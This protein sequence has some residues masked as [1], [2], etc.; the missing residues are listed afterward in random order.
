MPIARHTPDRIHTPLLFVLLATAG[1]AS[2]PPPPLRAPDLI[3]VV[4]HYAGDPVGGPVQSNIALG[5]ELTSDDAFILEAQLFVV[6]GLPA[7]S[8]DPLAEHVEL[9]VADTGADPLGTAPLI[10]PGSRLA[11]RSVAVEMAEWLANAPPERAVLS[12]TFEAVSLPGITARIAAILPQPIEAY[13]AEETERRVAL[14][15]WRDGMGTKELTVALSLSDVVEVVEDAMDDTGPQV[16]YR[17]RQETVVLDARLIAGGDPV[18]VI[19]PTRFDPSGRLYNVLVFRA[20]APPSGKQAMAAMEPRIELVRAEVR[21]A[22]LDAAGL[23]QQLR[24]DDQMRL[25]RLRGLDALEVESTRRPALVELAE[26]SG[27]AF[28]AE[29]ALVADEAI[30]NDVVARITASAVAL[31]DTAGDESMF[32]WRLEREV[33]L[34]FAELLVDAGISP[35]YEAILLHHAGE[36]GRFPAA[37]QEAVVNSVDIPSF[38]SRIIAEN[39]ISLEDSRPGARV[40][41]CDWL[42]EQGVVVPNFD[43]LAGAPERRAALRAWHES[44][45]EAERESAGAP[46]P[47]VMGRGPEGS[48]R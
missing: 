21:E 8:P 38:Y 48:K 10:S 40:R 44:E 28:T 34:M 14:L 1:C 5:L 45:S 13:G 29:V 46:D 25:R 20:L 12:T 35:E 24:I 31:H 26:S 11:Q 36:A 4:S 16:V 43:P 33:V 3:S 30:L 42:T 27:A 22:A 39:S 15:L 19:A 9:I 6:D 32:G 47:N 18:V 7:G 17:P 41:A 37:L 23:R 2:A